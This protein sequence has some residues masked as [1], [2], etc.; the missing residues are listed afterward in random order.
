[1]KLH[2]TPGDRKIKSRK[3][4]FVLKRHE[5]RTVHM[6]SLSFKEPME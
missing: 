2:C 6:T 5:S 1:M 3:S 4:N